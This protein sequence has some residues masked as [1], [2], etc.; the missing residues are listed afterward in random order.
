MKA[1]AGLATAENS[2]T[3]SAKVLATLEKRL[4]ECNTLAVESRRW[5]ATRCVERL[6]STSVDGKGVHKQG[7]ARPRTM[8][9]R[10]PG[11]GPTCM[12]VRGVHGVSGLGR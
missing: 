2:P 11:A 9:V 5:E 6:S 10:R 7:L 3:S 8:P 12:A 1:A 4:G